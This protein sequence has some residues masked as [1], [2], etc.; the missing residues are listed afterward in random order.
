[1]KNSPNERQNSSEPTEGLTPATQQDRTAVEQACQSGLVSSDRGERLRQTYSSLLCAGVSP[2]RTPRQNRQARGANQMALL[3][4]LGTVPYIPWMAYIQH[5]EACASFTLACGCYATPPWLNRREH[6][7]LAR[8]VPLVAGVGLIASLTY[9]FG[10]ATNAHLAMFIIA[11]WPFQLFD[12]E[13]EPLPLFVLVALPLSSYF[14]LDISNSFPGVIGIADH[15]VRTLQIVF[16]GSISAI[17]GLA[18]WL[19]YR[20]N[21]R[22]ETALADSLQSLDLAHEQ[23]K[24]A[25]DAKTEFLALLSHELRTPLNGVLGASELLAGTKL[26]SEQVKLLH[27]IGTSGDLLARQLERVWQLVKDSAATSPP[28]SG[29]TEKHYNLHSL[30][31]ESLEEHRSDMA[32]KGLALVQ[33]LD[34]T[35]RCS[36]YGNPRALRQIMTELLSNA[37]RFT[38]EG[39]LSVRASVNQQSDGRMT[40]TVCVEDTGP[41]IPDHLQARLFEPFKC[42]GPIKNHG[43]EGL[44]LGLALSRRLAN[45]MDGEVFVET[46][47]TGGTSAQVQFTASVYLKPTGTVDAVVESK[48]SSGTRASHRRCLLVDD[49]KINR[50]VMGRLLKSFDFEV[51]TAEDGQLAVDAEAQQKFDVIFMDIQ[52]PRMDG[53]E[54]IERIRAREADSPLAPAREHTPI[55]VVSAN[56][57]EQQ[58]SQALALAIDGYLLKPCKR[59][60]IAEALTEAGLSDL[61]ATG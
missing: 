19:F 17:F 56:S 58:R 49:N 29:A 1:M 20:G 32:A 23:V 27:T 16:G 31:T 5:E 51:V 43:L 40:A 8:S 30:L 50:L 44:G 57:S 21:Q 53:L 55:I 42:A 60:D 41:G 38:A 35:T 24:Q 11:C 12:T 52:M 10:T 34:E 4:L 37:I 7:L 33:C 2:E 46:L 36:L 28:S 48:C 39:Q 59:P 22:N 9:L 45:S 6:Y 25:S 13:R 61:A 54:A 18:L 14:A 15:A 26:G 47:P 3:F